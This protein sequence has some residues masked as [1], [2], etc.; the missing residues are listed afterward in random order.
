MKFA[1]IDGNKVFNIIVADSLEVAQEV[2]NNFQCVEYTDENPAVI[3][4][5]YDGVSFIAPILDEV[6]LEEPTEEPILEEPTEE[7]T[8]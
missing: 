3:G 7:P 6:V 8:E 1:V 5:T 4:W 2:S